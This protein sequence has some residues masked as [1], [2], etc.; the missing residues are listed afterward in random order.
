MGLYSSLKGMVPTFS[1]LGQMVSSV[2]KTPTTSAAQS[3]SN[4]TT[5]NRT[6]YKDVI[7]LTDQ[8]KLSDGTQVFGSSSFKRL[9]DLLDGVQDVEIVYPH[10]TEADAQF[11]IIELSS[12][13]FEL[14][15]E[16]QQKSVGNETVGERFSDE[17]S[18]LVQKKMVVTQKAYEA[19][20]KTV[21][22]RVYA[23]RDY[24]SYDDYKEFLR[25]IAILLNRH[26]LGV[27]KHQV[28]NQDAFE[29]FLISEDIIQEVR[30]E[31]PDL[32]LNM[33]MENILLSEFLN[34]V[35]AHIADIEFA[36][37]E[38]LVPLPQKK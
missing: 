22:S 10:K 1:G 3:N 34:Q 33:E 7:D 13:V 21:V 29:R 20:M 32:A 4:F 8:F 11:T 19:V 16:L 18:R 23:L 5:V 12:Q 17:G 14:L 28:Y 37:K 9:D 36:I 26:I 2:L 27:G 30:R 38:Q 35:K 15:D 31:N 6:R 24:Y 25:S